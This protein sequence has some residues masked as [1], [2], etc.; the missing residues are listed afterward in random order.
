MTAERNFKYNMNQ[1]KHLHIVL[2]QPEIH[3]NTGNISRTCAVTGATL[4]LIHP[5]GFSV[6]DKHLRRAGLDYWDKLHVF[7][8]ENAEAF[9]AA[10]PDANIF[11]YTTKARKRYTDVCYDK[12]VYLMFGPESRGLPED[13]LLAYPDACVRIPMLPTLRSLN[14]SNSVAIAA[15]EVLRQW[16]FANM[17]LSGQLHHHLWEESEETT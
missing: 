16:D 3:A 14:L 13:L 12:D 5:L 7:H 10:H 8:Y 4:H 11:Y 17:Q 1:E 6:D 2:Y 9:F 15:Y